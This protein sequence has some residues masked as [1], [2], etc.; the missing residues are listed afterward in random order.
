MITHGSSQGWGLLP[1]GCPGMKSSHHPFRTGQSQGRSDVDGWPRSPR[2]GWLIASFFKASKER[3]DC[4]CARRIAAR[5][6]L[7]PGDGPIRI[8]PDW[9]NFS[10]RHHKFGVFDFSSLS[11]HCYQQPHDFFISSLHS[12]QVFWLYLGWV[13]LYI[14][15]RKGERLTN[16]KNLSPALMKVNSWLLKKLFSTT[17][18]SSLRPTLN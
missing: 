15:A 2:Y 11:F 4:F 17:F 3:P 7:A 14:G 18:V 16:L 6:S 12:R 1:S 8:S 9:D 13:Q 5:S 10:P